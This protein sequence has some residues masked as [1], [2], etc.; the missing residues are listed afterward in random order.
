MST[1]VKEYLHILEFSRVSKR[2]DIWR[3]FWQLE[4]GAFYP[5]HSLGPLCNGSKAIP[6]NR[7][8]AMV[9]DGTLRRIPAGGYNPYIMPDGKR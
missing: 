8:H 4:R 9:Q 1:L 2:K 3:K 5:T 7:L 6:L